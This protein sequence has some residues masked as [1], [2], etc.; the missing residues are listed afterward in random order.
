MD[1]FLASARREVIHPD[2]VAIYSARTLVALLERH[3][4]EVAETFVYLSPAPDWRPRSVKE[5]ALHLLQSLHRLAARH[6]PYLA[7]GLIVCAHIPTDAEP[8]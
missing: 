6:T 2:H 4:W 3:G 7:D 5:G 8:E 1:V